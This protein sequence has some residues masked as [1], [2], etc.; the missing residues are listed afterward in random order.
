MIKNYMTYINEQISLH[1]FSVGDRVKWIGRGGPGPNGFPSESNRMGTVIQL[2]R[3][4]EISVEFDDFINGH[5]C[6]CRDNDYLLDFSKNQGEYGRC[7][8]CRPSDLI[9]VE[10]ED[11]EKHVAIKWYSK[12][13]FEEEK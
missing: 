4:G 3:Y 12:G 1:G 11:E 9:K 7:W 8:N 6:F 2:R 13:K 5:D 10:D